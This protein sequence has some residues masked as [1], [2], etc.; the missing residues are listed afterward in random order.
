[1][2]TIRKM[3]VRAERRMVR[4]ISFGVFCRR[5]PSTRLIMRSRKLSPGLAVTQ[6]LIRSERTRVPPVTALRSPSAPRARLIE[7]P[8]AAPAVLG[9]EPAVAGGGAPAG[10]RGAPAGPPPRLT[11]D[12]G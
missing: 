9:G 12:R 10:P 2:M 11:D 8:T 3:I 7:R 6:T 4:A 5:A 1:M